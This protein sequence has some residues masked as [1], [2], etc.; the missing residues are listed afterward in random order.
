MEPMGAVQDQS[1]EIINERS[2][3]DNIMRDQDRQ[4]LSTIC[5]VNIQLLW[6]YTSRAHD[7]LCDGFPLGSLECASQ[8]HRLTGL[9]AMCLLQ[10]DGGGTP[11]GHGRT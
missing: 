1:P 2:H 3:Q 4:T 10:A 11:L 8:H 5:V 7:P 9:V 6:S